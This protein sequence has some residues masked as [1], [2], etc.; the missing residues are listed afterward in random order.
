MEVSMTGCVCGT[1]V[2]APGGPC[3][4]PWVLSCTSSAPSPGR[5]PTLSSV[6]WSILIV[7]QAAASCPLCTG[8]CAWEVCRQQQPRILVMPPPLPLGS[9]RLALAHAEGQGMLHGQG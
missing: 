8:V 5:Y 3:P 6:L 1:G 9:P 2:C 7:L 4:S